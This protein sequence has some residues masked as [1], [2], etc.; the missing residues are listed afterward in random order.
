MDFIRFGRRATFISLAIGSTIIAWYY[1]TAFLGI[2]FVGIFHL[3]ASVILSSWVIVRI[4][5]FY[6]K[7]R[8]PKK[9]IL[10]TLAFIALSYALAAFYLYVGLRT[11][12]NSEFD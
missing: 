5:G 12:S 8:S 1:L 2:A 10:A 6:R 11:Y 7:R 3:L 9:E 4:I